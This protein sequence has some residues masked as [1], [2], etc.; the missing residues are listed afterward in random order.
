M[1]SITDLDECM[2]DLQVNQGCIIHEV[3]PLMVESVTELNEK[4]GE[5]TTIAYYSHVVMYYEPTGK[6]VH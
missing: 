5:E 3:M 4:T 6:R 2:N 1:I